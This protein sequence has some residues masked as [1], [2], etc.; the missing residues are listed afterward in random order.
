MTRLHSLATTYQ[1]LIHAGPWPLE[2]R[3]QVCLWIALAE[4]LVLLI[5]LAAAARRR[6]TGQ[7]STAGHLGAHVAKQTELASLYEKALTGSLDRFSVNDVIQ[8]VNSIRETGI[9]DIVDSRISAV[10]RM[11]IDEGEIIDAYNGTMR[12]EEA[13]RDILL[14]QEGSFTFIRGDL[15]STE[16]V[17]HKPTM[18]I[19]MEQIQALDEA[20]LDTA[21]PLFAAE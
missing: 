11:L 18:T 10:H 16:R 6:R 12:G 8:F 15:P 2:M 5:L 14:C 19:L 13:V 1:Q 3:Y 17:I 7:S 21:A 20:V 4:A 9:L